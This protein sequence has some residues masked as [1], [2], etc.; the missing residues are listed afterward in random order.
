MEIDNKIRKAFEDSIRVKEQFSEKIY[1]SL[2]KWL[3]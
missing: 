1:L 2:K 3:N